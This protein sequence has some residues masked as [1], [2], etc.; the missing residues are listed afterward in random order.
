MGAAAFAFAAFIAT[1]AL[2]SCVDMTLRKQVNG[3]VSCMLR[4]I[5]TE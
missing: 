5:V 4:G 3:A 2:P 1:E